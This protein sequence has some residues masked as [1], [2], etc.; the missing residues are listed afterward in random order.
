MGWHGFVNPRGFVW[1]CDTG[2]WELNTYTLHG[3]WGG[4]LFRRRVVCFSDGLYVVP[5]TLIRAA[6]GRS[7][8]GA[9]LW[10]VSEAV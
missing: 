1:L 3:S 4:S 9:G 6:L 10:T 2:T 8:G 7:L 5:C